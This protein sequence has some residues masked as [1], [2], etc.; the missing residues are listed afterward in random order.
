MREHEQIANQIM[1]NAASGINGGTEPFLDGLLR[2]IC[3]VP[4]VLGAAFF[5][6]DAVGDHLVLR[7]WSDNLSLPDDVTPVSGLESEFARL[8][9]RGE[10]Q[11]LGLSPIRHQS[12]IMGIA[13]DEAAAVAFVPVQ[14]PPNVEREVMAFVDENTGGY[15]GGLATYCATPEA[16]SEALGILLALAPLLP[17]VFAAAIERDRSLIRRAIVDDVLM[18]KDLNSV[19]HRGL[20][21]LQEFVPLEAGSVYMWDKGRILLT[22]RAT[23]G[24]REEKRKADVF[25]VF[26]ERRTTVEVARN[27]V[28]FVTDD[29][30][31]NHPN[32]GGKHEEKV[33]S[34]A[35]RSFVIYPILEFGNNAD[36]A[37]PTAIG[38]LRLV[39]RY[40]RITEYRKELVPFLREDLQKIDFF[41]EVVGILAHYLQRSEQR[42]DEFDRI[43]HGVR[44]NIE[45]VVQ[46]LTSL[47]RSGAI[48]VRNNRLT[49][50][51]G[52]CLAHQ[53][54]VKW[55]IERLLA[56]RREDVYRSSQIPSHEWVAL[57]GDVLM[58]VIA[59]MRNAGP[60]HSLS[61][62]SIEFGSP[63]DS[64]MS[65]PL[66]W[67]NKE[68]LTTVFR[69]ILENAMKY[70]KSND[71]CRITIFNDSDFQELTV[72]VRV[73]DSG[74]GIPPEIR[75]RI[76]LDG[77]RGD[78]AIRRRPGGGSGIG[79]AQSRELM[80]ALGGNLEYQE[81]Q[82]Q[83]SFVVTM[84]ARSPRM[85][86][87][88]SRKETPDDRVH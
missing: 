35:R 10:S 19:F 34:D 57:C 43:M 77:F 2:L 5:S 27:A 74:I 11:S 82:G 23:T 17:A 9:M 31:K 68:A 85:Y 51:I 21:K 24:L 83:T 29:I 8:L 58:P 76:F 60:A 30:S 41:C 40:L 59:L 49:H 6:L 79:L 47:Q 64:F 78:N 12:S 42:I 73:V 46:K 52:D 13:P 66:V 28:P 15:I 61:K 72:R 54:D 80:V 18:S 3:E 84:R 48:Q 50:F 53:N 14:Q 37:H 88:T 45:A 69:N 4:A 22:L 71:S 32:N 38:V 67:G 62:V 25:Y 7:R 16:A 70:S 81:S 87:G 75:D 39:N 26:D 44:N 55:Q 56:F 1:A 36:P 65:L 86:S 33:E 20:V 63:Y